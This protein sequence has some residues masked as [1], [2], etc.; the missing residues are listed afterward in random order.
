MGEPSNWDSYHE[1]ELSV[2]KH[3]GVGRE[4]LQAD[5][6]YHAALPAGVRKFLP[7]Q[8]LAVLA[9]IDGDGRLWA[10]MRSGRSGF[11]QVIDNQTLQIGGC[12]HPEDPLL[13]NLA[14]NDAMGAL[15]IDLAGRNRLRLNGTARA[16]PNGQILLM[17][18]QVYGNCQKYI[19]ARAIVGEQDSLNAP[20]CHDVRLSDSQ[21]NWLAQAD[22][23]FIATA[24]RQAGADASHRGGTPGFVRVENDRRLIFPD[25]PGNN[26]FNSL[27]NVESNPRA[28][29]LLPNFQTG[30]ALQLTGS[31]KILWQDPRLSDFA[32]AQRLIE[33]EI[34]R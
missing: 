18:K 12:G 6:M 31:A 10:S 4:G 20:A 2:Q 1:G 28:G 26:M 27:G 30:A 33:I 11:L 13:P 8:Q 14:A 9:T 25:Y 15:V 7:R 16:L 17:T 34:E 24:H 23:F 21:R 3:A 32:G 29:L 22:T 5:Q 19:Q